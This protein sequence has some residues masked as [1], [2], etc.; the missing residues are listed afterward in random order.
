M[1]QTMGLAVLLVTL[2]GCGGTAEEGSGGTGSEPAAEVA[3][4]EPAEDFANG[5][6]GYAAADADTVE[7]DELSG[8]TQRT[9]FRTNDAIGDVY[10]YYAFVL[11]ERGYTLNHFGLTAE[12]SAGEQLGRFTV[13]DSNDGLSRFEMLTNAEMVNTPGADMAVDVPAFP[14]VDPADVTFEEGMGYTH[15]ITFAAEASAADILAF[16]RSAFAENGFTVSRLAMRAIDETGQMPN[17][18]IVVGEPFRGD[19]ATEVELQAY[20]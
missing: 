8:G 7:M 15:E 6:P 2:A 17:L 14:G 1:K 12:N 4:Y 20:E 16:Y 3:S 13:R 18:N 11:G 5:T 10:D 9:K 19:H